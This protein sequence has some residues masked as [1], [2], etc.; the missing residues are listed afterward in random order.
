MNCKVRHLF[1]YSIGLLLCIAHVSPAHALGGDDTD[2]SNQINANTATC[3]ATLQTA[4]ATYAKDRA[5]AIG[6]C[7]KALVDC[8]EAADSTAAE[9]CRLELLNPDTGECARG[10]LDSGLNT[11]ANSF[12]VDADASPAVLDELVIALVDAIHPDCI[13]AAGVD[14]ETVAKAG[15][16]RLA[17]RSRLRR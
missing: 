13:L 1:W 3:M 6:V 15:L 9:A 17:C 8:D 11:I 5:D 4:G 7:L 10:Q 16:C 14:L 12:A 2:T